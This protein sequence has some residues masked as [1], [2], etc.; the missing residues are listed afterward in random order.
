MSET[1]PDENIVIEKHEDALI[2]TFRGDK[3]EYESSG[4]LRSET[5]AAA[6][7]HA[8]LPVIVD[9]NGLEMISSVSIGALITLS[10]VLGGSG[11][12]LILT[13]LSPHVRSTFTTC[14]IDRLFEMYDTRE[15]ALQALQG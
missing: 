1:M 12:R 6:G 13:G 11:Q 5:V 4:K 2:V 7:D 15:E 9:L 14:R 3:L 10:Q 8:G